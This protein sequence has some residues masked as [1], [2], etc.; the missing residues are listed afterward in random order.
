MRLMMLQ[1]KM[2]VLLPDRYIPYYSFKY[3]ISPSRVIYLMCQVKDEDLNKFPK[4]S[5]GKALMNL[6]GW[7]MEISDRD[8]NS[9]PATC[10]EILGSCGRD[11]IFVNSQTK[12]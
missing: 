5:K 7:E 11:L 12:K 6:T 8:P 10:P 3:R 4:T 9:D 1:I 2:P